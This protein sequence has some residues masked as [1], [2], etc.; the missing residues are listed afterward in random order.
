M[1]LSIRLQMNLT[2]QHA[3]AACTQGVAPTAVTNIRLTSTLLLRSGGNSNAG[4]LRGP[5]ALDEE[6]DQSVLEY[7]VTSHDPTMTYE[8]LKAQI[9]EA[10]STGVMAANMQ[11]F[12]GVFDAPTLTNVTVGEPTVVQ[13]HADSTDSSSDEQL[14]AGAIAGIVIGCVLFVVMCVLMAVYYSRSH[15]KYE[16]ARQSPNSE[17]AFNRT[18]TPA[19]PT[20]LSDELN[21]TP[22]AASAV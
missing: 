16:A 18:D 3:V 4:S 9:E 7:E 22:P 6:P 12:A 10:S 21:A 2:I 1:F 15:V 11:H 19:P 13:A 17:T 20:G 5:G 8:Q 14:S